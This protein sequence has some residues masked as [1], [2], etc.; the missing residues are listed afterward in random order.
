MKLHLKDLGGYREAC[1]TEVAD[2]VIKTDC[3]KGYNL[4]LSW[5]AQWVTGIIRRWWPQSYAM[6][7][8]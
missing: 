2:E 7:L 4:C 6:M 8:A 3:Q 1:A 5:P